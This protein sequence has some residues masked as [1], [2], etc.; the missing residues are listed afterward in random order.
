MT[1]ER[2]SLIEALWGTARPG[3]V[4]INL[5]APALGFLFCVLLRPFPRERFLLGM[6]AATMLAAHVL[7]FNNYGGFRSDREDPRKS[8][9]HYYDRLGRRGLLIW[10][11]V[12]LTAAMGTGV[13]V[14]PAFLG[15]EAC[16]AAV[17]MLYAVPPVYAKGRVPW[18]AVIHFLSGTAYFAL[19]AAAA[20]RW[21]SGGLGLSLYLGAAFT[22]GHFCQEAADT[23]ADR[24]AGTP[25][26]AARFGPRQGWMASL[27][28]F[29]LALGISVVL[30]LLGI[31]SFAEAACLGLPNLVIIPWGAYLYWRNDLGR[32][33]G[34][35]IRLY[36]ILYLTG[37]GAFL[38][39][40]LRLLSPPPG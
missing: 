26:F 22:A 21:E 36:R 8:F 10:S 1:R 32:T 20:G 38:A 6:V 34:G 3:Q 2:P 23:E 7:V 30:G 19:G 11:M 27:A 28:C 40:H 24:K 18:P 14:S 16:I 5:P 35:F 17:W 29:G 25:T 39:L 12:L 4:L 33:G 37:G 9:A 15:L 13:F 31:L